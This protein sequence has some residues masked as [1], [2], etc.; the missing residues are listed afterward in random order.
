MADGVN[1]PLTGPGGD[2]TAKVAT[3]DGGASFGQVQLI[4]YAVQSP[5]DQIV[6]SVNLGAGSNV[7]LDFADVTTG[8]IGRL[9]GLDVG[10]SVPCR[11]DIQVVDGARVTR[12]TMYTEP[13]RSTPW[14]VPF[15]GRFIEVTGGAG[16]HFGVSVTNL[17]VNQ[18][19]DVR[20]IGFWDEV[21]P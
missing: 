12:T 2:A 15:G 5:H 14:R 21:N 6:S 1:L 8:K 18:A 3:D 11:W 19:A 10:S 16:K 13:G 9:L 20:A 7:D 4:G 17:D